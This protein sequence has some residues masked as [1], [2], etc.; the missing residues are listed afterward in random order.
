M[1][2]GDWVSNRQMVDI[3]HKIEELGLEKNVAELETFGFTVLEPGRAAPVEWVE[4]LRDRMLEVAERRTGVKHDPGTGTHAAGAHPFGFK[5]MNFLYYL[6]LE[7]PV[8]QEA[9]L[10][11]YVLALHSYLLGFDCRLSSMTGLITWPDEVGYGKG[12]GLHSDNHVHGP[13]MGGMETH[14]ANATWVL[15]DYT[16]ENGALAV[17]PRSHVEGRQPNSALN[18]G[19][20]EAIPVEVPAG[21]LVFWNG[22]LWHGAYPRTNPGLRLALPIYCARAHMQPQEDYRANVTS[23]TL[24]NNPERLAVLLGLGTPMPWASPDGPAYT[25]AMKILARAAAEEG[26]RL[27]VPHAAAS[28]APEVGK[29]SAI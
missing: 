19:A 1:E 18:E 25:D 28:D 8:F 24:A 11:P 10:N 13:L 12:L 14:T 3:Y 23:E 6:L 29:T 2:I 16:R 5:H 15:T 22:N 26:V 7:D 4:R 21:S 27:P 17:V 9:L 20:K